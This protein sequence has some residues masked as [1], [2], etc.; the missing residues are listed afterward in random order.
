MRSPPV[1]QTSLGPV[2]CTL[3][4]NGGLPEGGLLSST[5]QQP[6]LQRNTRDSVGVPPATDTEPA[7]SRSFCATANASVTC[8]PSCP[9]G[10]AISVHAPGF[11]AGSVQGG[12]AWPAPPPTPL[13]PLPPPRPGL[14]A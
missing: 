11:A 8:R 2:P 6:W 10:G 5:V 12:C 13:P 4:E 3:G 9:T 1:A 7:N 14:P